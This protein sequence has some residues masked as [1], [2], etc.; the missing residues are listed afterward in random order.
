MKPGCPAVRSL[1]ADRASLLVAV[2]LLA[3]TTLAWAGRLH[4]E[5]DA[6]LASLPPGGTASVIVELD[7]QAD[8]HAAA[9]GHRTRRAKA[10]AVVD[11]LRDK[12]ART[13]GPIRA[14]LAREQAAG[15]ARRVVPLWVVNGLA[16]TATD[17]VIRALAAR[18]EVREVRLDRT[19]PRPAPLPAAAVPAAAISEWNVDQIRAPEVW[20]IDPA[21][22]GVGS[23]VGSFDTGVDG[24]HPDLA[25]RYRGD[26]TTSWFDPYGEHASPFDADGHGTHTTGTAVGG[27]AGGTNIGVAPGAVWIAAK[28]WD[29]NGVGLVSAF[30]QIFQWFLAPGGDPANAPDVVNMSWAFAEAGCLTDFLADVQAFRAAGI[31]PSFAAGNGGPLPGSVSSPGAYP[32]SFAV[33][34]TDIFDDVPY[35]SGR[36]PS[37]CDG[38]IKPNVGAPGDAITSSVPWGYDT[39]SGT[40]MA[41]P[42]VAGA[43]A[44]LRAINPALTVEELEGLLGQGAIDLGPA[45]PDDDYG[46]GRLDLFQSAQIALGGGGPDQPRVTIVATTPAATE[47]GLAPGVFTVARTGPTDA[48]LTVK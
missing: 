25:P 2:V 37:P 21:Y 35:F 31:F 23:V 18:P 20:S 5:V 17:P 19:V 6:H 28:A 27:D 41:A 1:S 33:G 38:G 24:T 13:Q 46:A 22:A 47:A 39:F 8:P 26:D 40:S 32:G 30:H 16:V 42:H 7:D 34:A 12:A 43:V 9:A 14:L 15:R 11:A 4:P 45:G 10:R 48:D 3:W 29:D 44:V 36:G